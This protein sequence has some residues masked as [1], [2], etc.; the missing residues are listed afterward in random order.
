M[1]ENKLKTFFRWITLNGHL[2]PTIFFKSGIVQQKKGFGGRLRKVFRYKE[3]LY[4][5]KLSNKG[6]VLKHSKAKFFKVLFRYF[7]AILKLSLKYRKLHKEYLATYDE[8][9]SREFWE[10]QF[11]EKGKNNEK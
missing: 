11:Y 9:T 4:L 6:F 8:L 10:K 5:H 2:I 1:H 7:G 3:V